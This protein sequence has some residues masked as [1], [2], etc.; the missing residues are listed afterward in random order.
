MARPATDVFF[1]L[2]GR[3]RAAHFHENHFSDRSD[4]ADTRQSG[5]LPGVSVCAGR[6]A[7]DTGSNSTGVMR[8]SPGFLSL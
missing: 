8:R 1:I 3:P 5:K 7:S 2:A 4:S 6:I